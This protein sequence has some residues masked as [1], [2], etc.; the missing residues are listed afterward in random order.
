MVEIE[1]GL[2]KYAIIENE[3]G[4]KRLVHGWGDERSYF[5]GSFDDPDHESRDGITS[6]AFWVLAGM[7]D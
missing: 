3:E 1:E 4:E 5:V 2:V 7:Y 6:N